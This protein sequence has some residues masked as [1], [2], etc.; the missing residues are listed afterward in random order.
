MNMHL[1]LINIFS[2]VKGVKH[3]SEKVITTQDLHK[4]SKW[5]REPNYLESPPELVQHFRLGG[6][7]AQERCMSKFDVVWLNLA[8]PS[9]EEGGNFL[10]QMIS[11]CLRYA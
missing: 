11:T 4:T 2:I 3:L 6:R 7:T 9:G 8:Y 5:L 1:T 10:V